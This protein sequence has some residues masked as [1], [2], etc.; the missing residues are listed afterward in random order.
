VIADVPDHASATALS[1]IVNASGVVTTRTT[2]LM[3]PEEIDQAVKK[4]P[5]YQAPGA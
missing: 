3:T 1:L 2:V 5:T 4:T